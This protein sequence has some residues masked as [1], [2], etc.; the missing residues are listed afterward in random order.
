MTFQS[1]SPCWSC[2]Y[3]SVRGV[4]YHG[5]GRT[6]TAAF[7]DLTDHS[8]IHRHYVEVMEAAR[9]TEKLLEEAKSSARTENFTDTWAKLDDAQHLIGRAVQ[10]AWNAAI[11]RRPDLIRPERGPERKGKHAN[12][13][14]A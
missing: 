8:T 4:P 1:E 13:E 12:V 10:D 3:Y 5:Q 7:R 9:K 2:L 11:A 6:P 14:T